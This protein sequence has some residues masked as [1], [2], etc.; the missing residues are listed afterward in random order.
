M[1]N[2]LTNYFVCNATSK[3]RTNYSCYVI[4]KGNHAGVYSI[5]DEIRPLITREEKGTP[6]KGFCSIEEALETVRKEIGP[7]YFISSH[8]KGKQVKQTMV[9]PGQ[10]FSE[11]VLKDQEEKKINTEKINSARLNNMP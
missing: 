6:Y 3:T 9:I 5:M 8:L 10:T 4:L 1:I 11:I 2:A 7:N